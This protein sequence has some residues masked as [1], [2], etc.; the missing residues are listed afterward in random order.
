[1]SIRECP[2]WPAGLERFESSTACAP[3]SFSPRRRR[4]PGD[5]GRGDGL[6][7]LPALGVKPQ[8]ALTGSQP[9]CSLSVRTPD[10]PTSPPHPHCEV[11]GPVRGYI[12]ASRLSASGKSGFRRSAA[13]NWAMASLDLR[14]CSTPMRAGNGSRCRRVPTEEPGRIVPRRPT[15][16]LLQKREAE[17]EAVF[18]VVGYRC[19]ASAS[20]AGLRRGAAAPDPSCPC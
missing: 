3:A 2:E 8:R 16:V 15:V 7:K 20:A 5:L 14:C 4:H 12:Q 9:A 19:T 11:S 17:V 6:G 10:A 18:G 1:M 13:R